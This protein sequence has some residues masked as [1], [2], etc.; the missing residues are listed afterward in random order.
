M[1]L[2]IKLWYVF[3]EQIETQQKGKQL[4]QEIQLF[5]L[6]T[7]IKH[8]LPVLFKSRSKNSLLL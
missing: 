7:Q 6:A 2:A 4:T 5:P 3:L 1:Y 8:D